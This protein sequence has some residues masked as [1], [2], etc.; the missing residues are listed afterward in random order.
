MVKL[1]EIEEIISLIN[2]GYSVNFLSNE[3]EIPIEQIEGYKKQLE[4]RK[5]VKEGIKSGKT[6][7]GIEELKNIIKKTS[8]NLVEKF[9][10]V[11][12]NAYVNKTKISDEDLKELNEEKKT[13]GFSKDINE[14]LEELNVQIPIKKSS[15]IKKKEKKN[16]DNSKSEIIEENEI[17]PKD[18]EGAIKKYTE[19]INRNPKNALNKRNLLAFAYFRAGKITEARNELLDLVEQYSSYTAYRQLVYLE[20][21]EG[22]YNDAKLWAYDCIEK[23]PDGIG[24]REQLISIARKE[25]D[26]KEVIKQLKEIINI[27]PQ[28]EKDKNRLKA[29][30]NR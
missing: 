6:Q 12:L 17:E 4:I 30:E 19:E 20:K 10:L 22:N 2:E 24:I 28:S 3:L 11:K 1:N 16:V 7:E 25:K 23:F 26:N 14:V 29:V 13:L 18:Y 5:F 8:N 21:T 9:M 27:N 15:N